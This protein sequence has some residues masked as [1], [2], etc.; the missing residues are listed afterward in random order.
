MNKLLEE[1]ASQKLKSVSF[2]TFMRYESNRLWI[3]EFSTYEL[4]LFKVEFSVRISTSKE[5]FLLD[6]VEFSSRKKIL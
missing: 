5:E 2:Q 1:V 3:G 6:L 4:L